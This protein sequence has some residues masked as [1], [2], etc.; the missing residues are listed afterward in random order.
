MD[1]VGSSYFRPRLKK[2]ARILHTRSWSWDDELFGGSGLEPL[3][4]RGQENCHDEGEK[5]DTHGGIQ[6]MKD[7]R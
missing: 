4:G 5:E 1:L 3:N 7:S 6:K 2:I